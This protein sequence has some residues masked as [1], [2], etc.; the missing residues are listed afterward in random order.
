MLRGLSL[1]LVEEGLIEF[2]MEGRVTGT[3]IECQRESA[4]RSRATLEGEQ[5]ARLQMEQCGVGR[6]RGRRGDENRERV[7]RAT[8]GQ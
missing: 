8:G 4:D 3:E 6:V 5:G 2:G 1:T 7:A